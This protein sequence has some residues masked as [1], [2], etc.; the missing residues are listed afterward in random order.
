[1]K[2]AAETSEVILFIDDLTVLLAV[3]SQSG[4]PSAAEI[5]RPALLRGKMQCI[6]ACTPGEYT[7]LIQAAPWIGDCFRTIHVRP[8]D[9]ESTLR[10]LQAR[11]RRYEEFHRV[12]Y[13]DDVLE[14]AV[15]SSRRYLSGGSLP[16]KVLELLDAAG[17]R[18]KLRKTALPEDVAEVQKRIR[19]IASRMATAIASHE[20]EKARFYSEEERKEKENL[21][22]LKENY[23]LD[24]SPSS[25]VSRE[26]V[27]GV[28]KSW[29]EY[30]F[31][32]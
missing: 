11:K 12:T 9:E 16:G 3:A 8:M 15:R 24:D 5:L 14:Y 1:M 6:G 22:I 30:P 29:A 26:D 4:S 28:I 17:A 31:C 10:V 32:P 21:R 23:P 25:I 27:E 18:V 2:A 13:A 19:F 7:T 20:F